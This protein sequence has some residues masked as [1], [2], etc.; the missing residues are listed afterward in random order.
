MHPVAF[1]FL[2]MERLTMRIFILL[3]SLNLVAA[4]AWAKEEE[5]KPSK[6]ISTPYVVPYERPIGFSF[7]AAGMT[8][9]TFEGRFFL[10]LARNFSLVISPSYQNTI[11]LPFFHPQTRE[12]AFF[13]IQRLNIGAGIRAHFYEYDS[14]NGWYIET[15]GRG[16]MTWVGKDAFAWALTPSLMFGHETVYESGYTVSFGVGVEWEFLMGAKEKRGPDTEYLKSAYYG[17]TKLPVMAEL[18]V[19][20]LW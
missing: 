15:L 1:G 13:D 20:W 14:R 10:G 4:S 8:S 3:C 2:T 19:G 9:L 12:A 17:I 5:K 18:S 16:G 11:E 7:N 6:Y